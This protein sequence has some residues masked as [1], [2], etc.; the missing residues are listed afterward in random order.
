MSYFKRIAQLTADFIQVERELWVLAI[1]SAQLAEKGHDVFSKKV[2]L[3][4]ESS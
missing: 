1:A 2:L 3:Q 4:Y